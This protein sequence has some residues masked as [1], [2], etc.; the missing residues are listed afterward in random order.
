M[1]TNKK[2]NNSQVG[3]AS[4]E[5][6]LVYMSF[7]NKVIGFCGLVDLWVIKIKKAHDPLWYVVRRDHVNRAQNAEVVLFLSQN[8]KIV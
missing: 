6:S 1:K 2:T 3:F 8:N 4:L 7:L 5:R